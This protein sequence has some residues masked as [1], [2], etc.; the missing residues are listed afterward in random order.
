MYRV[1]LDPVQV[2]FAPTWLARHNK[3]YRSPGFKGDQLDPFTAD[4]LKHMIEIMPP[5]RVFPR[6]IFINC[7]LLSREAATKKVNKIDPKFVDSNRQILDFVE[8]KVTEA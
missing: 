8:G 6:F 7:G 3:L 5:A 1:S 2:K 4:G